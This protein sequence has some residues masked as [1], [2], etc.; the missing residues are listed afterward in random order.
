MNVQKKEVTSIHLTQTTQ[1]PY[2]E[3]EGIW[4]VQEI[5]WPDQWIMDR[6]GHNYASR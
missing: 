1:T 3:K 4:G 2:W 5:K 6:K